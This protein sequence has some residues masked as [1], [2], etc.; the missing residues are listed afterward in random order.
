ML[1]VYYTD[2]KNGRRKHIVINGM[3]TF[4]CIFLQL[5]FFLL[6]LPSF[7][8]P[9]HRCHNP[10]FTI[11]T[12]TAAV[13][14]FFVVTNNQKRMEVEKICRYFFFFTTSEHK[15]F[16]LINYGLMEVRK[17]VKPEQKKFFLSFFCFSISN[18]AILLTIFQVL[19]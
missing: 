6:L 4:F 8:R 10:I 2:G 1:F 3:M 15:E 19:V 17:I 5:L 9:I 16:F 14:K 7:L 13:A 11:Y 12:M 18:I